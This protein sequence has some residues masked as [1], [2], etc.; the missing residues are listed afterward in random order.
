VIEPLRRQIADAFRQEESMRETPAGLR[1]EVVGAVMDRSARAPGTPRLLVL[2]AV[3]LAGA[4][5]ATLVGLRHLPSQSA[6]AATPTPHTIVSPTSNPSVVATPPPVQFTTA[7]LAS[8]VP[9]QLRGQIVVVLTE[10][11]LAPGQTVSYHITGQIDLVYDCGSGGP[12]GPSY[13]IRG[14]VDFTATRTADAQGT[15]SASIAIPPPA[16]APGCT[17]PTRSPVVTGNWLNFVVEDTTSGVSRSAGG[18]DVAT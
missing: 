8:A 18:L 1:D 14:P 16:G 5:I 13:P 12:G 2:V 3:L 11:S 6:P 9:G 17:P 7:R 4:V 10:T 15:V